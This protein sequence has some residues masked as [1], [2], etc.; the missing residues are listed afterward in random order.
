METGIPP[1]QSA[2]KAIRPGEKLPLRITLLLVLV[3]IT[4]VL[5][6]V[7]L[8]TALEWNRTLDSYMPGPLVAYVAITGAIWTSVG[9]FVLWSF[10][11]R[12]RWA[13][14]LILAAA[15]TYALWTWVDRLLIQSGSHAN[16]RFELIVMIV[17]LVYVG[18]VV[19][20]PRNRAYFRRESH[21]R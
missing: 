1:Q 10:F 2:A 15:G 3:L 11:R 8:I 13:G 7:R 18:A 20:D 12:A 4:T 9:C 6:A 21:D 16:W 5:S 19:L 17:L 14:L